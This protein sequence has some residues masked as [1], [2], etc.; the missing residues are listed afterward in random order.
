MVLTRLRAK[1][2]AQGGIIEADAVVDP[3]ALHDLELPK[4][5]ESLVAI[6]VW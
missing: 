3:L 1:D 5:T 2:M 6:F 4:P